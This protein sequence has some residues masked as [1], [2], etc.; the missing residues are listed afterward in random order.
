MVLA[1][2]ALVCLYEWHKKEGYYNYQAKV[3]TKMEYTPL[4]N[5]KSL[6]KEVLILDKESKN[7]YKVDD[8]TTKQIIELLN[9][10]EQ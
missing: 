9:K 10:Q 2:V 7:L 5:E 1:L 4:K 8:D 6:S 3:N